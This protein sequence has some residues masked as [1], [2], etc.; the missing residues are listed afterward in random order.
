MERDAETFAFLE[1]VT[2]AYLP[3]GDKSAP[4][5][6]SPATDDHAGKPGFTLSFHF[7]AANPFFDNRVLTKTNIYQEEVGYR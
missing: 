1:D 6:D 4:K 3:V 2:F 5:S 7:G